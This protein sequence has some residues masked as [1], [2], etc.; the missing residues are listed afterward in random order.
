MHSYILHIL[1]DLPKNCVN[2]TSSIGYNNFTIELN[3]FWKL[4]QSNIIVDENRVVALMLE[5]IS[6]HDL[7]SSLFSCLPHI[8]SSQHHLD[9]ACSVSAVTRGHHPLVRDECS[10][11]EPLV[12]NKQSSHPGILH[13]EDVQLQWILQCTLVE[14]DFLSQKGWRCRLPEQVDWLTAKFKAKRKWLRT[15]HQPL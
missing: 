12:I 14:S 10:S 3:W 1:H 11:T 6:W 2:S 7:H 8:V 4:D 5:D 13:I 9:R 15:L